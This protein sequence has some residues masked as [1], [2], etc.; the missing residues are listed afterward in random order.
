M[1]SARRVRVFGLMVF[2][3][4]L[5]V[6]YFTASAR[7]SRP[8]DLRTA[9]DFYSKT[10]NAL[11][12]DGKKDGVKTDESDVEVKARTQRLQEAA[13]LAKDNANAKAPKP[14]APEDVKGVGSASEGSPRG[15]IGIAGRKKFREGGDA[16]EVVK[17]KEETPEEHMVEV[18]LN[19]IL[20]RAPSKFPSMQLN[21]CGR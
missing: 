12:K 3:F 20:K 13:K 5:T 21:I 7:Q 2:C 17:E 10:M 1:P 9:G 8:R 4:V 18:E 19:S 16:Q 14:D 15:E 6:L 11:P